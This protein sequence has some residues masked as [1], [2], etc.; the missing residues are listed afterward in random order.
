M[1][2]PGHSDRV[3]DDSAPAGTSRPG[4]SRAGGVNVVDSAARSARIPGTGYGGVPAPSD[5]S[6]TDESVPAD[7]RSRVARAG[8]LLA[9]LSRAV[10]FTPQGVSGPSAP[11]RAATERKGRPSAA[12]PPAPAAPPAAHSRLATLVARDDAAELQMD[13]DVDKVDLDDGSDRF[14]RNA[15]GAATGSPQDV[16]D[17]PLTPWLLEIINEHHGGSFLQWSLRVNWKSQS[18]V[19]QVNTLVHA[20]DMMLSEFPDHAATSKSFEILSRR[21]GTICVAR[22]RVRMGRRKCP[23]SP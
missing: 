8:G 2:T 19:H 18:T 7:Q 14:H 9:A 1:T 16:L 13:D 23:R 3:A 11:P 20:M 12:A 5:D 17:A 21:L 4:V 22:T 10:G 15:F 6:G